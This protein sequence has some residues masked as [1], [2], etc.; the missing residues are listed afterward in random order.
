[1]VKGGGFSRMTKI[2]VE[3]LKHQPDFNGWIVIDSKTVEISTTVNPATIQEGK[4][5]LALLKPTLAPDEKIRVLEYH[6]DEPGD[7]NRK[8]CVVLFE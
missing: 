8:S 6:N 4:G 1:M 3:I 2:L 5:K 7:R